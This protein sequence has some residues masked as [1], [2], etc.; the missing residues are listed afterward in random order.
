M[1]TQITTF[2]DSE[3]TMRFRS[4]FV[5][6][7]LN[8]K[9]AVNTPPGVYRGFKLET[10]GANDT[11]TIAADP[12]HSDHAA[13]FQTD[14]GYSVSVRKTG[15]DFSLDLS[16]VVDAAE[17]TWV[18]ALYGT[19]AIGAT[20]AA[21]IRVYELSPSD[22]YSGAS[23][24]DEL[25][26]LG[27]VTIPA[28]GGVAIPAANIIGSKRDM[29][30][31]AVADEAKA[32]IPVVRN[33]SFEV[34]DATAE[35]PAFPIANP[36]IRG[37]LQIPFWQP[38]EGL[39]W[40]KVSTDAVSGTYSLA[41]ASDGAADLSILEQKIGAPLRPSGRLLVEFSKRVLI[42]AG[43]GTCSLRLL[44]RDED[45][46]DLTPVTFEFPVDAVDANFVSYS[47]ITEAPAAAT[48]LD[49]I[50]FYM[51]N[52]TYA[53]G[54]AVL[55]DDVQ[56]WVEGDAHTAGVMSGL[57]ETNGLVI[58]DP[59]VDLT[60]TGANFVYESADNE[61][62]L[63]YTGVGSS[64]GVRPGLLVDKLRGRI[65][66]MS[67]DGSNISYDASFSNRFS[68]EITADLQLDNPSNLQAGDTWIIFLQQD[69]TGGWEITYD[70]FYDF[71]DEGAPSFA[72]YGA[73]EGMLLSCY[74]TGA[75]HIIVTALKGYT[76]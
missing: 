10:N 60:N 11:V 38:R 62:V 54:D 33:G 61:V 24:I 73:G 72:A 16:S 2:A 28:G 52:P 7:T 34:G 67:D 9:M 58:R 69:G 19:Y 42:A 64:V 21:E 41:H 65:G 63:G 26:V 44:F 71:G 23:E 76:P 40:N 53:A 1:P 4:P 25:V 31:R 57:L 12:I 36:E 39:D 17:K 35:S 30:W 46:T 56:I 13:V 75:S 45:G 5:T 66:T 59:S 47:E 55:L 18:I 48:T 27:T 50:E 20:T 15:G 22:E 74:A 6:A 37:G 70:T 43:A 29:A 51:D 68:H 8:E 49:R 14:T 32:W 3:L